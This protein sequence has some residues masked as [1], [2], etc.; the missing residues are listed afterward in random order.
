MTV[1][2]EMPP[3]LHRATEALAERERE[4]REAETAVEAA[5]NE[6]GR[7]HARDIEEIAAAREAGEPDPPLVGGHE[8]R[9]RTALDAAQREHKIVQAQVNR[10]RPGSAT[11]W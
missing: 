8:E 4:L 3:Q 2:I 6:V 10:A 9:A 7:A 5:E 1:T 11:G